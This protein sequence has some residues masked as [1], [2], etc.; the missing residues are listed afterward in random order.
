MNNSSDKS[1]S[2]QAL[3]MKNVKV[4]KNVLNNINKSS[5]IAF[6]IISGSIQ[7]DRGSNFWNT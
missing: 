5:D 7:A 3:G 1:Q 2:S 6:L 4:E